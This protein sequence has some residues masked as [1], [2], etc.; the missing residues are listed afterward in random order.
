[1]VDH[2]LESKPLSGGHA[3]YKCDGGFRVLHDSAFCFP[4]DVWL[5]RNLD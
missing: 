4:T 1:M 5:L 2:D 3:I